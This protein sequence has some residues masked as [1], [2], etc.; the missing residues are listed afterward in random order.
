MPTLARHKPSAHPKWQIGRLSTGCD[1]RTQATAGHRCQATTSQSFIASQSAES[2]SKRLPL[3]CICESTG[4][5]STRRFTR[6]G[7]I[8]AMGCPYRTIVTTA[9]SLR[10]NKSNPEK[11]AFA[12]FTF[13]TV[14]INISFLSSAAI[15]P[16]VGQQGQ[17]GLVF[18]S[19]L[20]QFA[21]PIGA[22]GDGTPS[23]PV[24]RDGARPS[25]G[26]GPVAGAN[27]RSLRRSF[28]RRE[29]V[30]SRRRRAAPRHPR[31][32]PPRDAIP[33]RRDR[34]PLRRHRPSGSASA[35]RSSRR[36]VH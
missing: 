5:V 8:C 17:D 23:L 13:I 18:C 24:G 15:I 1:F 33:V 4:S 12:S 2:S 32:P 3:I 36:C 9:R 29:R 31:S 30:P 10:T 25:R 28:A 21:T 22:D 14:G 27:F 26:F 6:H 7:T 11:F 19:P 16:K 20:N 35:R 34:A